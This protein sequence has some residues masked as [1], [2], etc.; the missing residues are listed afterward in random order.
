M[1]TILAIL[2]LCYGL[3][4]HNRLFIIWGISWLLLNIFWP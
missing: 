1:S 4:K 2:V 3:H